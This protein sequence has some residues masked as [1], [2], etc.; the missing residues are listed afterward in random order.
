MMDAEDARLTITDEK[1]AED[2]GFK[3]GTAAAIKG[4]LQV[5]A[6]GYKAQLR[7]QYGLLGILGIALAADN[8]WAALRS[9][10]SVFI[11]LQTGIN[12]FPL[13]GIYFQATGSP[14][15]TFG[16]L[17]ILLHSTVCCRLRTAP[18]NP[19][20][21]WALALDN[22][23]PFSGIFGLVNEGL[24]RPVYATLFVSVLANGYF[25]AGPSRLEK[26]SWGVN[27]AAVFLI[28]MFDIFFDFRE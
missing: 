2:G 6:A 11:P 15:G 26:L 12:T 8:P 13:A 4:G 18:T 1:R 17:F 5:N 27:L 7:R 3:A 28:A 14:S 20:T 16:L 22:A 24:S 9:S 23:V 21:Y 10:I 19:R 25:P